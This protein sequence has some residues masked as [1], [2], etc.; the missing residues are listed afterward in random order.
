MFAD[1]AVLSQAGERAS[2]GGTGA[3]IYFLQQWFN[4]S[5]PGV[6]E[7][8]YD[9]ATMRAFARI[10]LGREPAPDETSAGSGICSKLGRGDLERDALIAWREDVIE[11]GRFQRL[12]GAVNERGF[13]RWVSPPVR[14]SSITPSSASMQGDTFA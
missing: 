7:A 14:M 13:R 11:D 6:E 4:L 1:R 9:Q 2:P 3:R 8:L 10:D 5:D 12:V